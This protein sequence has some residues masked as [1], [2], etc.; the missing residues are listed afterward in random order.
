MNHSSPLWNMFVSVLPQLFKEVLP[1]LYRWGNI[2]RT[3]RD[4]A[5]VGFWSQSQ[6]C[7]I[8]WPHC[9]CVTALFALLVSV[10]GRGTTGQLWPSPWTRTRR[11][12]ERILCRRCWHSAWI[13]ADL[14]RE[15]A[16]SRNLVDPKVA[17]RLALGANIQKFLDGSR[18]CIMPSAEL[19]LLSRGL[20]VAMVRPKR[21]GR[22][23]GLHVGGTLKYLGIS[24]E[25]VTLYENKIISLSDSTLLEPTQFP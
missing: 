8:P 3:Q 1:P 4:C 15:D 18:I 10:L 5:G 9:L 6:A 23:K 20:T 7:L 14:G 19:V 13:P 16:F 2:V 22:C 17:L 12:A 24:S 25:A 11:V 21:Q